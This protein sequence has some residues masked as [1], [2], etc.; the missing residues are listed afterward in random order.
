[1]ATYIRLAFCGEFV[2]TCKLAVVPNIITVVDIAY[3]V[4]QLALMYRSY[5][6]DFEF[7]NTM[8]SYEALGYRLQWT[9]KV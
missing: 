4:F 8:M 6:L 7:M 2:L 1:M 9:K 5:D 3:V